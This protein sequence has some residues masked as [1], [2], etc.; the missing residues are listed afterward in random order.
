MFTADEVKDAVQTSIQEQLKSS[1][2]KEMRKLVEQYKKSINLH[3]DGMETAWRHDFTHVYLHIVPGI[4][5]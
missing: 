1:L 3:G 5:G 4:K 2:S